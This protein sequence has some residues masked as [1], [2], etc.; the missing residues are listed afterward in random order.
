MSDISFLPESYRDKEEELK[1]DSLHEA[2][3]APVSMH[4]PETE[5]EDVEIIEVDASE[6]DQMLMSEPLYSRV[7]YKMSLWVDRFKE[8]YLKARPAEPAP[9]LPPQF[10]TPPKTKEKTTAQALSKSDQKESQP[11][12]TS[13][14]A[15]VKAESVKVGKARIIPSGASP[16]RVRIIKRVRKPVHVSL[17]DDE[18]MRQL[19][20][21]VPKRKFTLVFLT[22]LFAIVF[23]GAYFLLD[24]AQAQALSEFESVNKNYTDLKR[25]IVS[26]QDKWQTFQDL[27]PRLI[28]LNDLL[29]KHVSILTLLRFLEDNTLKDVSYGNFLMDNTGRVSLTVQATS[30]S[31]AAR[32][33]MILRQA[34]DTIASVDASSFAIKNGGDD[35]GVI[36]QMLIQLKPQA[37]SFSST[38]TQL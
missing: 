2:P 14:S 20:V 1:K 27:E 12:V 23:G 6:V 33:L 10:F 36:F 9:K 19:R 24:K 28:V 17:L 4:V 35:D 21:N 5:E 34:E 13:K 7:Y 16:R 26:E 11:S 15:A 29:D 31:V 30:I 22:I 37:L 32:Q 25:Q 18:V 8:R 3:D 38:S